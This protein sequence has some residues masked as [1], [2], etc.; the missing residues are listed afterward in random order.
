MN[1]FKPLD[2]VIY[3]KDGEAWSQPGVVLGCRDYTR[4][5]IN[6][7]YNFG[8]YYVTGT[9]YFVKFNDKWAQWVDGRILEK[10]CG[11]LPESI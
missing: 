9:Q 4:N 2:R 11:L 3:I 10:Y 8:D 6:P 7:G 5:M 1:K